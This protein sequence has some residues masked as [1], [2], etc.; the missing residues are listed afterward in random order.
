MGK[1][2]RV[3]EIIDHERLALNVGSA[4]GAE[5]HQR[6]LVY[7][8]SKREIIDPETRE[9]LGFLEVVR[10][11]GK[12]THVQPMLCTIT[13]DMKESVTIRERQHSAILYSLTGGGD[14]TT[15]TTQTVAF[16][17]AEV[18]DFAK[19]ITQT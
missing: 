4:D 13:S 12:V 2:I 1:Q 17:K 15:T 19:L 10:G 9:S 11:T 3:V 16:D 18:G 6:Y 5:M 14:V 7:Y 8:V